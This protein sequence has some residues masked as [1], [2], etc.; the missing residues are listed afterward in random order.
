MRMTK[1]EIIALEVPAF[2][3]RVPCLVC[4]CGHRSMAGPAQHGMLKEMV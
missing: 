1:A 2:G 3:I 4:P